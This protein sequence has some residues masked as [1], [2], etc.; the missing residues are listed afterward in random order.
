MVMEAKNLETRCKLFVMTNENAEPD[1]TAI[2]LF[3]DHY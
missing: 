3:H 2:I 1:N